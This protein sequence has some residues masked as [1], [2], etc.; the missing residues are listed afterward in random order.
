MKISTDNDSH[1]PFENSYEFAA[2]INSHLKRIAPNIQ[3]SNIRFDRR[4]F[5]WSRRVELIV[6][7]LDSHELIK[8]P[9]P[10]PSKALSC[11][12]NSPGDE[13]ESFIRIRIAIKSSELLP[14]SFPP[15]T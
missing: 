1:H 15:Q 4:I 8:S 12:G 9:T 2:L 5:Q 6:V 10:T 13:I 3:N 7:L 11:T 14:R